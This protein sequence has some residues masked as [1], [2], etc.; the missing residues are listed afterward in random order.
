MNYFQFKRTNQ[1]NLVLIGKFSD[2]YDLSFD[3]GN[4]WISENEIENIKDNFLVKHQRV[5]KNGKTWYKNYLNKKKNLIN[6]E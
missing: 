1:C 2:K 6:Y 4:V 3:N 5:V